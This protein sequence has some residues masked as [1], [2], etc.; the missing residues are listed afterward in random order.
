MVCVLFVLRRRPEIVKKNGALSYCGWRLIYAD[1]GK[2]HLEKSCVYH[3]LLYA[4]SLDIQ[5]RPDL[6]FKKT[7]GRGLLPVELKSGSI[8]QALL[9]HR[10]DLMQ[11]A[12]YFVLAEETFGI[13][14]RYGRLVYQDATFVVRNSRKLRKEL[15][16]TLNQMRAML[17][18]KTMETEANFPMCRSCVCNGTVCK[19]S[20]RKKG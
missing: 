18:G 5:G 9:P 2:E 8:G 11:L 1:N 4:Q 16:G 15:L 6:I 3:K 10:G 12:A 17:K 20:V 13:K 19:Y 7:I 14:P